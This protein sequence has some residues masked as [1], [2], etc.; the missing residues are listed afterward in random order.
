MSE[1]TRV[2]ESTRVLPDARACASFLPVL[3][4][5]TYSRL[6]VFSETGLIEDS[7]EVG[8]YP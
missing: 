8:A 3:F 2:L 1:D 6:L 7:G 5:R 4:S